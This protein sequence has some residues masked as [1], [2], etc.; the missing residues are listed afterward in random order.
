MIKI[1]SKW[2]KKL[3]W[4]VVLEKILTV[5]MWKRLGLCRTVERNEN[6][7]CQTTFI[8]NMKDLQKFKQLL[9]SQKTLTEH[10]VLYV[11]YHTYDLRIKGI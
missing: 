2:K 9:L 5:F 10:M 6:Y 7:M 11:K 3:K 4:V 1:F 8:I